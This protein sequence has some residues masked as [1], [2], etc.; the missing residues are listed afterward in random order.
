SATDNAN[1]MIKDLT[2]HY[3]KLRQGAI[4]QE[5]LEI[6]G[7]QANWA[8]RHRYEHGHDRARRWSGGGRRVSRRTPSD[9]ER[10]DRRVHRPGS[11]R[12]A[13]ARSAAAPRRP[14]GPHHFYVGNRRTQAR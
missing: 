13:D 14:V 5:L 3:N 7:G 11:P 12:D 2:L 10:L 4:T 8:G 6:A 9:H 1:T